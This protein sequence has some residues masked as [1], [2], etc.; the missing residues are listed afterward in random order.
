MILAGGK[1][2]SDVSLVHGGEEADEPLVRRGSDGEGVVTF[3]TPTRL[4]SDGPVP[5]LIGVLLRRPSLLKILA[6]RA[7]F[8]LRSRPGKA[9]LDR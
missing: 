5:A 7:S 8:F 1:G 6:A 4:A 2:G 3:F 9:E